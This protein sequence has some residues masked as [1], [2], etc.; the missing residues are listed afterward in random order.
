[1]VITF[2]IREVCDLI[3]ISKKKKVK[4]DFLPLSYAS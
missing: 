4:N 3:Y 1:M 2:F